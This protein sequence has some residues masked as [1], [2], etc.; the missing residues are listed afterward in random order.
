MQYNTGFP[1][2]ALNYK[3]P[4][5]DVGLD[6]DNKKCWESTESHFICLDKF[7]EVYGRFLSYS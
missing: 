5:N 1:G 3:N 4:S 2:N 6:F 7:N